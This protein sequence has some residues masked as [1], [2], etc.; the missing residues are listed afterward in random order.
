MKVYMDI[1]TNHSADVIRYR[2]GDAAGYA[3]RS[4]ADYPY[5]RRGGLQGSAINPGFAGDRD[6]SA[7]NGHE[8]TAAPRRR[9][10]PFRI[11]DRIDALL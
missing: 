9:M 6:A 2:D 7:A 4:L 3:Y 11:S 10:N 5:S 1:I 8:A